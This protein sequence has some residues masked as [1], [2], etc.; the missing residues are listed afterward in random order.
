MPEPELRPIPPERRNAPPRSE[1]WLDGQRIGIIQ[2]KHLRGARL[3]F[4]ETIAP[5][6]RTGKPV[7]LELHTDR[8]ERIAALV[9]FHVDPHAFEQN[10]S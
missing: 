4:Y 6:P 2:E 8:D 1:V 7:S 5:H 3:T 10:W 9:R